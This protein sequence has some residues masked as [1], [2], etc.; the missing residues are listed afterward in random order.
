MQVSDSDGRCRL[1]AILE[2][3]SLLLA[4]PASLMHSVRVRAIER[5]TLRESR[6]CQ[7]K[8]DQA[9]HRA[10]ADTSR[11]DP[12][13]QAVSRVVAV[14]RVAAAAVGSPEAVEAAEN[15]VVVVAV[16]AVVV[17]AAAIKT[18][19]PAVSPDGEGAVRSSGCAFS[20]VERRCLRQ[21]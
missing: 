20:P 17:K 19:E 10:A 2:A 21:E 11:A 4:V 3:A 13:A 16:R 8:G 5:G 1:S 12:A 14:S 18:V 15:Q 7:T 6:P 9:V